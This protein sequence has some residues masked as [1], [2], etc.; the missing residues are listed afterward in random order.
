MK[1]HNKRMKQTISKVNFIIRLFSVIYLNTRWGKVLHLCREAVGAM[2]PAG[3]GS[4]LCR[5]KSKRRYSEKNY[6]LHIMNSYLAIS[7]T[8]LS[9][10]SGINV[11]Q[12]H[13][14][15][16]Q[17]RTDVL[18]LNHLTKLVYFSQIDLLIY[19]NIWIVFLVVK[20]A[21]IYQVKAVIIC[22]YLCSYVYTYDSL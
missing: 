18:Q 5:W 4:I 21:I 15:L 1:S 20:T 16:I 17:R 9:L 22:T 2:A 14:P 7:V 3:W 19:Q 8:W 12:A 10:Y 11:V 6:S 13:V